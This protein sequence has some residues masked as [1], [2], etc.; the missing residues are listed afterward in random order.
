MLY[1][2][3]VIYPVSFIP[4]RWQWLISLNPMFSIVQGFRWSLLGTEPPNWDLF[5]L[6]LLVTTSLLLGGLI[7]FRRVESTFADII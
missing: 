5:L 6:S 7:F 1:L 4:Q 3:P 2:T